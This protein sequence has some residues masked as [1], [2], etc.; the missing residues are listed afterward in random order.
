LQHRKWERVHL[1]DNLFCN[2]SYTTELFL[3]F[4]LFL[5]VVLPRGLRKYSKDIS[6]RFHVQ[7]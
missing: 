6:T 7:K 5:N 1:E 4:F 2:I 3:P